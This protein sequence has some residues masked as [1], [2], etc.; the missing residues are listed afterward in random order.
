MVDDEA[1]SA[2]RSWPIWLANWALRSVTERKH[3]FRDLESLEDRWGC[4][5]SG[6][7][8]DEGAG[9]EAKRENGCG[10]ACGS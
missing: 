7:V 8:L 4:L 5:G 2:F 3:H 1:S 9:V 10:R 6:V